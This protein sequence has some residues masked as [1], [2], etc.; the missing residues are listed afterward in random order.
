MKKVSS[1][2]SEQPKRAENT[3]MDVTYVPSPAEMAAVEWMQINGAPKDV[4]FI[5]LMGVYP[6][7]SYEDRVI[8]FTLNGKSEQVSARWTVGWPWVSMDDL[9]RAGLIKK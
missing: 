3:E 8:R 5:V 9:D 6:T 2:Q 4:K 1:K 7:G